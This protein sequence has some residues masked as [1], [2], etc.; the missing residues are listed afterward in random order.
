MTTEEVVSFTLESGV[1]DIIIRR[2]KTLNAL[3]KSVLETLA[4]ILNSLRTKA[5][6]PSERDAI[7][8]VTLRGEGDKAFVAGADIK[9]MQNASRHQLREFI[10]LGQSVMRLIEELPLPV[11]AIV[12]GYAIGGGL[13]LALACDLIIASKRAK[14]GA[15]EINLGLIPGF[16]GTQRLSRRIGLGGARRLTYLGENISAEEAFR[17]G[18]VDWLVEPGELTDKVRDVTSALAVKAP[19]ALAAAKRSLNHADSGARLAGLTIEVEEFLRLFDSN[20][21]REG[22]SAFVE[23]RKPHFK[24][25]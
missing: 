10:W 12:D 14:F 7:R 9:L 21:T 2:A 1:G 17:L 3:D 20:D 8:V 25:S 5:N 23:K 19:L 22:L 6:E 24:G 16:G 13:E 15:A 18:L 4:E 11:I